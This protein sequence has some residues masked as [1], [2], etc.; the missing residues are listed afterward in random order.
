MPQPLKNIISLILAFLLKLRIIYI[1]PD[2]AIVV[3]L[4]FLKYLLL[5]IGTAFNVS[6]L[7]NRIHFPQSLHGCYTH[8]NV[9]ESQ[10]TWL[11]HPAIFSIIEQFKYRTL[12]RVSA[13]CSFVA[14]PHQYLFKI[15]SKQNKVSRSNHETCTIIMN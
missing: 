12:A 3:L 8:L 15:R 13:K 14:W 7:T 10:N 4:R 9:D 5:A 11:V 6:I 2:R 1:L